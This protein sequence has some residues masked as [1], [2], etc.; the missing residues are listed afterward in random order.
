MGALIKFKQ[1]NIISL[2]GH[3]WVDEVRKEKSYEKNVYRINF[4][5]GIRFNSM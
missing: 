3:L 2:R 1:V 4:T 5:F